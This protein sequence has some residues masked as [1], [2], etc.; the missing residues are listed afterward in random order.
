MGHQYVLP[1]ETQI[2]RYSGYNRTT[3]DLVLNVEHVLPVE[4]QINR[5]TK[6]VQ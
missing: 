1:E 5:Q 3:V 2:D 6:W 4:T